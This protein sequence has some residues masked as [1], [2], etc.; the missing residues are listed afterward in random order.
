MTFQFCFWD[1]LKELD[2]APLQK[3]TNL[4]KLYA[5]LIKEDGLGLNILKVLSFQALSKPTVLF[6]RLFFIHLFTTTPPPRLMAMFQKLKQLPDLESL[7]EGILFFFHHYITESG[8]DP[9]LG[10]TQ[11]QAR[12]TKVITVAKGARKWLMSGGPST[13]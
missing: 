9:L 13:F 11:R 3:L 1:I 2:D 5:H 8:I 4:S 12:L 6:L 7:V 10:Q